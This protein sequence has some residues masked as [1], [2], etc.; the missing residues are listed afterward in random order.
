MSS[1]AARQAM[2]AAFVIGAGSL[3][4]A[5][6]PNG[7]I[8]LPKDSPVAMVSMDWSGSRAMPRG[9]AYFVDVHAS[10]TLRNSTQKHIR[11]V[12]LAVLAQEVTP[13]RKSTRLNS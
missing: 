9:S 3:G 11:G 10:L 12:T 7:R 1:E 13:D 2:L 4:W 8:D 5:Q 6:T